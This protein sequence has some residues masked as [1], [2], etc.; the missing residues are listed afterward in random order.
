M[1]LPKPNKGESEDQFISRCMSDE[2]MKSEYGKKDQRVAV[3]YSQ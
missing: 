2:K 3:C 1:P